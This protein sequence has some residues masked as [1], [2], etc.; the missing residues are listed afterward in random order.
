MM[1]VG[2]RAIGKD[3]IVAVVI[4]LNKDKKSFLPWEST[5]KKGKNKNNSY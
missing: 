5:V 2:E 1:I 4:K 3:V